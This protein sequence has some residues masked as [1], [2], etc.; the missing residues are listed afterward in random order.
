MKL[1][2]SMNIDENVLSINGVRAT[3]LAE[4]YS[5]PLYVFDENLIRQNCREY[6]NGF[7]CEN[8]NNRVAYAG[9]AFLTL[10]MCRIIKDE[11]LYLDVV[12][13]GELFTAYKS[14][15]P[16]EKVYFH[17]NNKTI[18]EIELGIDLGVGTFVADNEMEIELIDKIARKHNKKQRIYLRITPGIEAHTHE[19]IKTGQ[20]DSKFGF[21]YIGDNVLNVVNKVL[22]L[23]NVE[24]SGL[25]CHIGSQIFDITPYEDA[26]EIMLT[27]IKD[28][29]NATGYLIKELDL[30]GG[31]GIYYNSDDE[32]KPASEYCAAILSKADQVCEDLGLDMPILT[33][34]PGR[35]I[36]GN[37][38][39][40]LYKVGS[41]K[42]VPSIRKY[43]SVDGG[44]TDNIR[45]A[46]Y[47][48]EYESIVAN[49]VNSD[50]LEDVTVAGKCCESGDILINNIRL[51]KV[52]TGDLLAIMSTGAYGYSMANNYNKVPKAAVVMIKDGEDRL[53]CKRETYADVISNEI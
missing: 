53:V 15:F 44:M 23:Q 46:L 20:L 42:E 9:K 10:A 47:N 43:I 27:I 45:P 25:H 36:V 34:E 12:S 31:F 7:N 2:G 37:A 3:E 19:Y 48:A 39:I 40:T 26:T 49:K 51:P 4:K 29:Y 24:L 5:T 18:D 35:S 6:Y 41:I 32:P 13:G 52:Q 30:G 14:G 16:L 38:G 22:S 50:E 11:N 28:I 21:A 33:I 8:R 17:G 1:F